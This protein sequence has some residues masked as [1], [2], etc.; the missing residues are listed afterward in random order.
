MNT[1]KYPEDK[2]FTLIELLVVI[3]IIAILAGMLLPA[4]AKAKEKAKAIT[5]LNSA[6][7]I[8]L[9]AKLYQDDNEGRIVPLAMDDIWITHNPI[10]WTNAGG[11]SRV[12]WVDFIFPY[13]KNYAIFEAPG[14][15]RGHFRSPPLP[16]FNGGI[17]MNHGPAGNG[18]EGF[19]I[20]R[21]RR[22]NAV[23]EQSVRDPSNA[24]PFGDSNRI[25][26]NYSTTIFPDSWKP[27][28]GWE[29][30]GTYLYRIPS[31]TPWWDSSGRERIYGRWIGR[32][33]AMF[34]DGHAAQLRPNEWGFQYP[35]GHPN[36]GVKVPP[37]DPLAIWDIF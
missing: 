17:G 9:G 28:A 24:A 29:K 5:T 23:R 11:R 19:G 4:L 33:N 34:V 3:A 35:P 36:A 31:N 27:A 10:R 26:Q 16:N 37:R 12:Y 18:R 2:A 6:K 30:G 20:W 21:A 14:V 7:Q 25:R 22:G 1:R 13:I 15:D 32:A 8:A